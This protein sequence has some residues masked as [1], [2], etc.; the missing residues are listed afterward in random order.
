MPVPDAHVWLLL[1][2]GVSA[3]EKHHRLHY[4]SYIQMSIKVN[5]E[6]STWTNTIRELMLPDQ[7]SG[8]RALLE[9]I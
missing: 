7:R 3:S 1:G 8:Q 2:G 9:L 5:V 6:I 4:Y